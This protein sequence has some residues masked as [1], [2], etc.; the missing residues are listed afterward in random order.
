LPG[1]TNKRGEIIVKADSVKSSNDEI[2]FF[3]E[4]TLNTGFAGCFCGSD[5]PYL[6]IYRSRGEDIS[7][8]A[9]FVRVHQTEN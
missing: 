5:K 8:T 4:A 1:K 7:A 6:L 3:A 2:G 9:E